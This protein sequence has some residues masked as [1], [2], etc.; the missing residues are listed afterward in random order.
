M[1]TT[2]LNNDFKN[3]GTLNTKQKALKNFAAIL[4]KT[5]PI[6]FL[7]HSKASSFCKS[8]QCVFVIKLV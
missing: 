5:K 7:F 3:M 1:K 4:L 6:H 2:R 8:A